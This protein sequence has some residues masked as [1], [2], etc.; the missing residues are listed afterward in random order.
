MCSIERSDVY[1]VNESSKLE[2]VNR[3][4]EI[5]EKSHSLLDHPRTLF[6]I[7]SLDNFFKSM[8]IRA[9]NSIH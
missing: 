8:D 5:G 9:L 3:V 1:L 2:S 4:H 6:A 7:C